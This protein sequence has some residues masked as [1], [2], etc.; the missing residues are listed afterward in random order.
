MRHASE[1]ERARLNATFADLCRIPSPSYQEAEC[2]AW[3]RA[4]LEA[5]GLAVEDDAAG[6]LL[7]RVRGRGER[8]IC[9]C[10]HVDT[11]EPVAPIDPVIV[12]GG[13]ENANDG[14]LGADNKAAVA[15]MLEVARR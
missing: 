13:W 4:Q 8:S 15:V 6:N 1:T 5:M 9:L 11:V 3:V 12:D 14:I 10:A 2:A 7:A